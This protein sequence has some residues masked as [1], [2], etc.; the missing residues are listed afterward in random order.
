LRDW[1]M[2][3]PRG[4]TQVAGLEAGAW[5]RSVR[6]RAL[7]EICCGVEKRRLGQLASC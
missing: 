1:V 3:L 6:R 7:E 2:L 5:R 4:V